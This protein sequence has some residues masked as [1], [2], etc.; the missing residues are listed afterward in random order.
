MATGGM[1]VGALPSAMVLPRWAE[2][3]GLAAGDVLEFVQGGC[4]PGEKL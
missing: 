4:H 3:A 1:G 2:A